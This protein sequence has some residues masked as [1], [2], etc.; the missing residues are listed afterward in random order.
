MDGRCLSCDLNEQTETLPPPERLYLDDYWRVA[1]AWS[2]LPGWLVVVLR[3]HDESIAEL[4][5][6]EAMSSD[7]SYAPR[8]WRSSRSSTGASTPT[9][10]CS[11]SKT[12][13]NTFTSM[14]FQG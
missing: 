12:V 4:S 1:H 14:W 8:R 9:S 5:E 6:A 7:M 10:C 11:Q 2:S 13:I 3:R